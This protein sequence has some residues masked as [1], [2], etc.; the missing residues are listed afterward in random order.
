MTD[1]VTDPTKIVTDELVLKH[2]A[3]QGIDKDYVEF[4]H[5][6]APRSLGK[7]HSPYAKFYRDLKSNK[8]MMV[9]SGLPKVKPDGTRIKVGW[10]EKDGRYLSK[11]NLFSAIVDQGQ[12]EVTQ[13]DAQVIWIPQLFFD[14]KE[15][16]PKTKGAYLL[17]T[18]PINENYH[19]NVLE[20]DYGICKRRI[21]IVHG[22]IRETWLFESA[23]VGEVR[24]KHNH[25]GNIKLRFGEYAV[26][27]D[28]ELVPASVF[29]VAEYPFEVGASPETFY[30]TSA[31][32]N[33]ININD[34][35]TYA[36]VHDAATGSAVFNNIN[37]TNQGNY[38]ITT[39]YRVYR[40][41]SFFN[42]SL[43][44]LFLISLVTI[45]IFVSKK[46]WVKVILTGVFLGICFLLP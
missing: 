21:R 22:I 25:S 46:I 2:L 34:G 32:S 9:V 33:V 3:E 35:Q 8:R 10:V 24:V 31:D 1:K 23:P 17:D 13:E 15:I 14:G 38:K 6:Y 39:N 26:D 7:G 30:S 28:T 43:V 45:C 40:T 18:D 19:Q 42:T 4:W 41:F 29:S 20:W 44:F 27:D 11:S 16:Y 5:D 37:E 36:V 12:I